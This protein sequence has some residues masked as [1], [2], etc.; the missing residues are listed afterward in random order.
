MVRGIGTNVVKSSKGA[1]LAHGSGAR[2]KNSSLQKLSGMRKKWFGA[3]KR[4]VVKFI[5][6]R[7]CTKVDGAMINH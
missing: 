5:V 1:E 7:V 3:V 4:R 2:T 6:E